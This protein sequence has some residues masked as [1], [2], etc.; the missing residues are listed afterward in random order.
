MN[1]F[2]DL[3]AL[4][5]PLFV[6]VLLGWVIGRSRRWRVEYTDALSI[7]LLAIPLPALL[8]TL[9]SDL[10][11]LPPVDARLLVAYFGGCL[12][13]FAVARVI[14]LVFYRLDGVAQS[15]FALGG[16]FSNNVFLGVPLAK[17]ALGEAA[18]P[19]VGLVLVFNTLVLWTLVT[20]SVEWARHGALS[21]SG[22]RA[23]VRSVLTNP[24]IV[25]ILA[26]AAFG[27]TGWKLPALI[28]VPLALLAQPAVPLSLVVLGLGLARY[29]V[30]AGW[31]VASAITVLKLAGQPLTVW[32]IAWLLGLPRIETQAIVL[33]AALPVGINVY[34]MAR[35][36]DSLEA[37]VASSMLLSTIVAAASAPL[38]L[39]LMGAGG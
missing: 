14:A 29:G 4:S 7:F 23:T 11:K 12:I 24:L 31:K 34:L 26:G 1:A 13:V 20:I 16:I 8:F 37:A 30:G 32:V 18:M 17:A 6:V 3:V 33:L 19:A 15:V 39:S 5:A 28:A 35:E 2:L 36:F 10:S 27:L 25:A 21:L 9:M 38:V 22:F